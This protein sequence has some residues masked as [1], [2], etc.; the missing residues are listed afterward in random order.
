MSIAVSDAITKLKGYARNQNLEDARAITAIDSATAFVLNQIGAPGSEKE[1]SFD[2]DQDQVTYPLPVDFAEPIS[3]RFKDDLLNQESKG[4]DFRWKPPELLFKRVKSVGPSTRLFSHYFGGSSRVLYVLAKNSTASLSLDT[5]DRDNATYWIPSNDATNVGDDTNTFKEGSASLK[6]DITPAASGLDRATLLR[7]GLNFNLLPYANKGLFKCYVYL[8]SI[9]NLI[10]ISFKWMSSAS[11]YFLRSVTTQEDGSPFVVGWNS[12]SFV[13]DGATE[14][15][16]PNAAAIKRF[17]F[18]FDY[19]PDYA[20]GVNFRLDNLRLVVP[21]PMI[22]QYYSAY[23][24]TDN[25][26]TPIFRFSS[27]TDLFAFGDY[28]TE[29]LELI[30]LH[31]AV[32][33]NPQLLVDNASV[34]A[35]YNDFLELVR[36]RYPRKRVMN[37]LAEPRRSVTSYG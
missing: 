4:G 27:P 28:A 14:V 20:G 22:L 37:L 31:A 8:Q 21:D 36:R 10:S 19:T 12:L 25:A 3:L 15:G 7:T 1:Y 24:G 18:D 35:A 17:Q 6:F 11:D 23:K 13:W 5:F 33:L 9:T 16:S 2:F 26:G 34:K 29:I 30:A 32:L